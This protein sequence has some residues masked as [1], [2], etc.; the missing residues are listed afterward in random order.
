M[1]RAMP[2][3]LS[4]GGAGTRVTRFV[5]RRPFLC[6]AVVTLVIGVAWHAAGPAR[7][8]T[9]P[10]VSL[11]GAPFIAGMRLSRRLMGW[12]AFTPV[13]GT[14]FGLAPYLLAD[15]LLA[16]TRARRAA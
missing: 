11:I 12:T 13:L 4:A 10:I 7:A 16:R 2:Q 6:L 3:A 5:R 1:F 8:P 14:L 15:W 9:T